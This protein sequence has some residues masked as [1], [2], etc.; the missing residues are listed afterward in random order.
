M[1]LAYYDETGDDGFPE[2][3]SPLFVLTSLYIHYQDWKDGYDAIVKFR[4]QLH[5]DFGLPVK[6]ELHTK[7]FI[8]DKNP[9]NKFKLSIDD[10]LL[11][12]DLFCDLIAGL[13]FKIVNVV[14][15]KKKIEI[16]KY[17]VLDKAF[18]YSIQRI[19]NDLSKNNPPKKFIII[20]DNGRVGK[21]R[22][23][24]RKIQ[25]I[26]FIPSKFN[27]TPYRQEI[28]HLI[29]DPLPKDS[30]ESYFIQMTDLVSYIIY[31]YKMETLKCGKHHNRMPKEINITK[32][33]EWLE[34]LKGSLNLNAAPLDP[35]GIVCYPK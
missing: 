21:M 27:P 22:Y 23:T 16:A 2:Y 17:D 26:N 33:T 25:N 18:T 9:Y 6:T 8:L 35:Y 1:Y 14:I 29:E 15:H 32:M 24:A 5:K 12:M 7:K 28:K 10:R 30:K 19:E 11:I 34:K 13:P 3:S 20:T 31:V 4:R